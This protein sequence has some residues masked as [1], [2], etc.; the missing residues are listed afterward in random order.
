MCVAVVG[1]VISIEKN[2]AKVDFNGAIMKVSVDFLS[3]IKIGN[4]LLVHA[5]FALEKIKEEQAIETIK[6]LKE[7][8][9][10]EGIK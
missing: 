9:E 8:Q 5:G 4:Y 7:L 10:V 6:T 3:D 2:K 1:K